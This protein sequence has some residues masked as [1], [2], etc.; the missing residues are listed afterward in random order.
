MTS[1]VNVADVER[2]ASA[3]G[4][5]AIAAYGIKQLTDRSPAGAA[6]AAAGTALI[7]RGATGHCPMYSAA[8]INTANGHD[9][10]REHLAG[11]RGVNVEEAVTI[12][13]T[14]AELYRVWRD[15][16]Q[17]PRFMAYLESVR[18]LDQRRSHWIA[19]GPA[20]RHVEWDAEIINE[21]PDE[22]IGWRTLDGADVISAGS[23]RFVPAPGGRGTQVRVRMQYDPP[24][25]K[26]GA[27]VAWIFGKEPSQTVLED[28]RH[29]KQLMEAG[30]IPTTAG[31]PRGGK[32]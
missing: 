14:A 28:L 17:L 21:I 25:G 15:F 10:T 7:V 6:L 20:G 12:N 24:G 19:K 9:D 18:Q 27:A 1:E 31:Q 26:V 2:W 8:G 3:L 29:F 30:E 32:S 16:E 11:A 22:L 5:A 4:G 13:R 23:V